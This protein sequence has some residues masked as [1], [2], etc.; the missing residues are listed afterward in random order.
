M[1]KFQFKYIIYPLILI[2]VL[3]VLS[4]LHINGSSVGKYNEIIS[5]NTKNSDLIF[6]SSRAIRSDEYLLGAPMLIS[7]SI[8]GEPTVN[9][10][11]GI[12]SDLSIQ[13]GVPTSNIYT[14]FKPNTWGFFLSD[15]L[16]FAF[17]FYWWIRTILMLISTYLLFLVLTKKNIFL[18]IIGS[19]LFLTSP[20]L[21]WWM[22][23]ES[24]TMISLGLVS[25][26]ML[27]RSDTLIRKI[28]SSL[29]LIYSIISFVLILYPP[30]QIP[31]AWVAIFV[32]IATI[33]SRNYLENKKK[34][35]IDGAFLVG[36]ALIVGIIIYS[37]YTKNAEVIKLM[38]QTTYPGERFISAGQGNIYHLFNGFYNI[39]MQR[40]INGAPYG[41]QCEAS[42]FLLLSIFMTPWIIY[43]NIQNW[44]AK[45]KIDWIMVGLCLA[46]L[47]FTTWYLLPLPDFLS[48]YTGLSMVL[49]QRIFMGIGYTNILMLVML[50]SNKIY[51]VSSNK[52]VYIV[53]T[54]IIITSLI[55]YLTGKSLYTLNPQSFYW[56]SFMS[57]LLKIL[58]VTLFS[59][60]LIYLLSIQN[61]LF[62]YLLLVFGL[63]SVVYINPL[64]KGLTI[65]T[66]TTIATE[67][68][69]LNKN[70]SQWIVYGD[71]RLAQYA[72]ANGA[73]V[74]NGIHIYPQFDLWD[75]LDP[76]RKYIDVYNRFAH[77]TFSSYETGEEYIVLTAMDSVE[78]NI[79][80]CDTRLDALM[81]DYVLTNNEINTKCLKEISNTNGIKI[82]SRN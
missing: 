60:I 54:T 65:L 49:P 78:V 82:Y 18:S 81:I 34:V 55:Y 53:I 57:P 44:E 66:D 3:F 43:K 48:K 64:R 68:K 32:G 61:K 2:I 73:D 25:F 70:D 37:F 56:P 19:L 10:D 17:S 58:G 77:I 50:F 71:H 22:Q 38:T 13:Y 30:F 41:N 36:C 12:E 35:L 5:D 23:P 28:L 29:G 51:K 75:N 74:I 15:N 7:Q 67:I 79:D 63:C 26:I 47:L 8:N 46:T 40:D 20:F 27:I 1:F 62:F 16:E 14:I 69:T 21:Q 80:I 33:L 59:G 11:M 6:G 9:T 45:K 76:N 39:L 72:L 42:N 4:F 31:L 52:D 24:I